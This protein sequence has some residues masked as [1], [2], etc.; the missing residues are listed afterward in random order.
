MSV[1]VPRPLAVGERA[2]LMSLLGFDFPGVES[3]RRQAQSAEVVG[4][5]DC[6]C[7]SIELKVAEDAPVITGLTSRLA[8]VE[9]SVIAT[10]EDPSG[11]ILLFV[12]EGRLS[13]LEY[14][15]DYDGPPKTW[16]SLD[17][18]AVS[19]RER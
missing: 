1:V 7:P 6:G 5:C 18:L 9:A 13:Y 4:R 3:L 8:P 16:P 11:G 12:E 19:V 17:R 10:G 15:C 2:V 14:Y